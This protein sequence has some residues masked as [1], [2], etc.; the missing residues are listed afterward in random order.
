[1][2]HNKVNLELEDN[3]GNSESDSEYLLEEM[4]LEYA[5]RAQMIEEDLDETKS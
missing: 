4:H 5:E 2:V 3:F 1:M